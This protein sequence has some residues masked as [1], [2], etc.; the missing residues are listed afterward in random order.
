[1]VLPHAPLRSTTP[2]RFTLR[3]THM[4][5]AY[6]FRLP[7]YAVTHTYWFCLPFTVTVRFTHGSRLP[8]FR[9]SLLHVYTA[10][11][12]AHVPTH[13]PLV[14]SLPHTPHALPFTYLPR[15]LAVCYRFTVAVTPHTVRAH[16]RVTGSTRV[17]L[18]LPHW[19]RLYVTL[20]DATTVHG[21]RSA[22]HAILDTAVL[23]LPRS[24][25]RYCR[26]LV[27]AF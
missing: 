20:L 13:L 11:S 19:L 7:D 16:T 27:Y 25:L 17:A 1:M 21:S 8:R 15:C 12:T 9:Y 6:R 18:V 23:T 2:P 4:P 3:V 5:F 22:V 24:R 26:L 14:R 10:G